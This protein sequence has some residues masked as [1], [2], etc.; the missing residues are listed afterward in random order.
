MLGFGIYIMR[1]VIVPRLRSVGLGNINRNGPYNLPASVNRANSGG[2]LFY[3]NCLRKWI[4]RGGF[5]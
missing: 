1:R 3:N 5:F 2:G 4:L